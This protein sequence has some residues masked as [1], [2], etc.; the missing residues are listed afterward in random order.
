MYI[1]L[2]SLCQNILQMW[3]SRKAR[4]VDYV[5]FKDETPFILIE[6]KNPP[7]API[8]SLSCCW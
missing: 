5:I 1:T 6:A 4:N 3:A 7:F 2:A 8:D